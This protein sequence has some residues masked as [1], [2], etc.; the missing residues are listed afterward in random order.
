M[1]NSRA[2]PSHTKGKRSSPSSRLK[3]KK[4]T[5]SQPPAKKPPS[6]KPAKGKNQ[7]PKLPKGRLFIVWGLLIAG[8]LGLGWRLYQLQIV[9]AAQ[10]Q[11]KAR[12]QQTVS[13]R[14]YIPRRS[15]ID[16]QGNVLAT[17][18]I[19]Y[20]LYAHPKL[21]SISREEVAEKLAPILEIQSQELIKQFNQ[22]ETGIKVTTGLTEAIAQQIQTL[23]LDGV[24]LIEHY[25]RFYPQEKIGADVIGY[26]DREHK[27][28][29]GLELGQKRL[30]ERNLLNLYIRRSGNGAIMPA[31]LPDTSLGFDDLKLQLTIDLRLHRAARSALQQQLKKYNAKRGAVIVMDATDGSLLTLVCEPTFDPNEY[32]KSKVELFK[33]WSVSDLYEPGSTFKPINIAIALDA[34]VI[35]P[36]S[37]IYDSGA[38]VVDGWNIYNASKQGYGSISIAEVLQ[39]SSNVAMIEIMKR[40]STKDYYR[41]LLQL[42]LNE[43]AGIDLPGEATGSLKSE[44]VFTSKSIEAAVTSFGQGFSMTPIKLVQLHGAL[45]NGGRLVTPHVVKGL[46]DGSGHLH[47]K[48]DYPERKIFSQK[49]SYEVVKMMETVVSEGTGEPAQIP[50]YRIGGKTG[51]AQKAGPRGGYIPNAK[52]TSFVA[53]FPVDSPRYVVLAVVDEP[54]GANTYG[55]T[56]AAPIA[57]SVMEA[58]ISIKGIPPSKGG[59]PITPK[60]KALD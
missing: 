52:I 25:A 60:K 18:R 54:K 45:A 53:I 15:V 21:F 20:S 55:S 3:G 33:N 34:G 6:K 36:N 9:E 50:Y 59:K 13:L 19:V 56:V 16:G 23:R 49:S 42:G 4:R 58:L 30:L 2:K 38:A 51:T 32:Y 17:D 40:L 37:H 7:P 43:K 10:L 26:V 11:K 8:M 29:A 44:A 47:W 35:K 48:P 22:R 24:E 5:S 46:V 12:Q 41:R 31:F 27:G 28:Q 57:K 39:T 14:P 1:T